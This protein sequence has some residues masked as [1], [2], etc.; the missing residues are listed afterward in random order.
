MVAEGFDERTLVDEC[1]RT[2]EEEIG[3]LVRYF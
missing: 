2:F 1:L 3:G